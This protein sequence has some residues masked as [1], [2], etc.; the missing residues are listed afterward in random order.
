[1]ENN[2]TMFIAIFVVVILFLVYA[3]ISTAID[4]RKIEKAN[5]KKEQ[6]EQEERDEWKK[7]YDKEMNEK[8]KLKKWMN[9]NVKPR[10]EGV[11]NSATFAHKEI[12][13]KDVKADYPVLTDKYLDE[14]E[15]KPDE[16]HGNHAMME[17]LLKTI[18]FVDLKDDKGLEYFEKLKSV[19]SFN[20]SSKEGEN[21]LEDWT[22]KVNEEEQEV[23][24]PKKRSR[25]ITQEVKDK[26]WNRDGGKCVECG[27]NENL[28]F[29]HIIPHSKGGANT[30]R[31][32]QLLC[33][34]CNRSKS[35]KKG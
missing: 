14:D 16:G 8:T 35:A 26:G 23:E 4:D 12:W 7:K 10:V 13:Y 30:Y 1:M 32:I 31:N 9:D 34:P 15:Y 2:D 25:R 20:V 27:S 5:K 29:D 19:E 28:E 18:S 22:I 6:K 11:S 3:W 21:G 17:L 24:T 33:E